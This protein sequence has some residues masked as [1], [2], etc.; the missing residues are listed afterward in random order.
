MPVPSW[1][2]EAVGLP[3]EPRPFRFEDMAFPGGAFRDQSGKGTIVP[4]VSRPETQL[5]FHFLAASYIDLGVDALHYGQVELMN[6]RDR[7]LTHYARV[8]QRA[9]DHA[10]RKARRGMVL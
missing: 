3:V 6:R 1:A 10:A 5:W 8:F 7:D 4:D 2:F 9:R